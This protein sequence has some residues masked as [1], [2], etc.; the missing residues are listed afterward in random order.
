MR[1]GRLALHTYLS[2]RVSPGPS[3]PVVRTS[4]RPQVFMDPWPRPGLHITCRPG[5]GGILVLLCPRTEEG[6][7]GIVRCCQGVAYWSPSGDDHP[8]WHQPCLVGHCLPF[9]SVGTSH[10]GFCCPQSTLSKSPALQTLLLEQC[11]LRGHLL[12]SHFPLDSQC[13]ISVALWSMWFI[14]DDWYLGADLHTHHLHTQFTGHLRWVNFLCVLP[15]FFCVQ[16]GGVPVLFC[17]ILW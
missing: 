3:R 5:V 6:L 4:L 7:T 8:G 17:L 15:T 1:G 16:S 11:C 13:R 2:P 10:A 9:A 14:C 12:T